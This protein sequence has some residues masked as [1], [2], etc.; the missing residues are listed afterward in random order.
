MNN[1]DSS[2]FAGKVQEVRAKLTD[3]ENAVKG[4]SSELDVGAVNAAFGAAAD[5]LY[6]YVFQKVT[7]G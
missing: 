5:G 4:Q 3:L 2:D 6:D 1:I 7:E